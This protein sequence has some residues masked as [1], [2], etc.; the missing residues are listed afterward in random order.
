MEAWEIALA[1]TC[2]QDHLDKKANSFDVCLPFIGQ[3]YA[4]ENRPDQLYVW[5]MIS[6]TAPRAYGLCVTVQDK[7]MCRFPS[8]EIPGSIVLKMDKESTSNMLKD[9]ALQLGYYQQVLY[10]GILQL[11]Y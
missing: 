11:L 9:K 4:L 8:T 7:T 5:R 2:L 1:A 10:Y 6:Q 3:E